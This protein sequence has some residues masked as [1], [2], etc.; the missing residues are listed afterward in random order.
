MKVKNILY[1]ADDVL[2][3][4]TKKY[5]NIIECRLSKGILKY[6]RIANITKFIKEYEIFLNKYKLN[7]SLL[8]DT[9]KI[10]V[11]SSYLSSDITLLKKI[12]N[13][14]NYR[15]VMVM[16][17]YKLY[18]L[19]SKNVY[20]NVYDNYLEIIFLDEY[21]K[22]QS[23]LVN[24]NMFL[25]KLDLYKY[26]KYIVLDREIYLIGEGNLLEEIFLEYEE[27]YHNNTYL[28]TNHSTYL[29]DRIT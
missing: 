9:L 7:N 25:N 17:E 8:G 13:N 12:F 29:L 3:L 16:Y 20:L 28:Y 10:I 1:I 18:K 15:K 2:Y 19:N 14:F 21:K 27:M 6:G 4:K 24:K 22:I 23:I 11:N 5:K 26:L